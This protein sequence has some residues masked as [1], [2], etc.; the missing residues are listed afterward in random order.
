MGILRGL[1]N[2]EHTREPLKPLVHGPFGIHSVTDL[3]HFPPTV[4][5]ATEGSHWKG[6]DTNT[7]IPFPTQQES[8]LQAD[9]FSDLLSVRLGHPQIPPHTN[10]SALLLSHSRQ[11]A[12]QCSL[13]A[14]LPGP[15]PRGQGADSKGGMPPFYNLHVC[16][17]L[18]LHRRQCAQ[19][20]P[21][22]CQH[23]H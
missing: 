3:T 20:A 15:D 16:L 17:K 12:P 23:S 6:S 14:L 10:S 22:T 13:A 18:L 1:Q 11:G 4:R 19:H 5:M 21:S 8:Q 9:I 2:S 7:A